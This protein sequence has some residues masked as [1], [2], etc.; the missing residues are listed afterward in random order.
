M[1]KK[2]CCYFVEGFKRLPC[3]CYLFGGWC[4]HAV[5]IFNCHNF[6]S[7]QKKYFFQLL[8]HRNGFKSIYFLIPEGIS[9][10][11][12]FH[13]CFP[14]WRAGALAASF[15][16]A[17]CLRQAR[18]GARQRAR[19]LPPVSVEGSFSFFSTWRRMKKKHILGR[20][21]AES[22]WKK[23]NDMNKLQ[24]GPSPQKYP[25]SLETDVRWRMTLQWAVFNIEFFSN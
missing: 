11:H 25:T 16:H 23:T 10:V 21:D 7:M 9:S 5:Y 17:R 6:Q 20:F 15:S 22:K 4:C 18:N 3:F 14:C 24:A 1:L 2:W 8:N 12:A 19:S 13:T